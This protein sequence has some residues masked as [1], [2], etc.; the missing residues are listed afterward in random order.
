VISYDNE[1]L[2]EDP[3]YFA[4]DNLQW[5]SGRTLNT[6]QR[7]SKT[8]GFYRDVK[9]NLG[10][11]D[12]QLRD[13]WAI[14]RHWCLVFLAYSLLVGGLWDIDGKSKD[15]SAPTLGERIG[16]ATKSAFRGLVRWITTQCNQGRSA[17]EI[18]EIAFGH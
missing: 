6:Y 13:L 15:K 18:A 16:S 7:R 3:R 8:E 2:K 1:D 5:E 9:Q 17:E 12:Y 14:K 4:T 10:L 11:E